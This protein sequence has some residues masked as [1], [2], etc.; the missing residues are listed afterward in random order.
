MKTTST[1]VR[2]NQTAKSVVTT[3]NRSSVAKR[4]SAVIITKVAK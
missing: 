2:M 4:P 3:G 1:V